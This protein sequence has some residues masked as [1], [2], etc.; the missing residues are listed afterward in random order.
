[1]YQKNGEVTNDSEYH[2]TKGTKE[3]FEILTNQCTT[4]SQTKHNLKLH[5]APYMEV[6]VFERNKSKVSIRCWH[7]CVRVG[8][9]EIKD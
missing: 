1:M 6:T 8:C 9:V 4:S 2:P 7:A 5:P 3:Y